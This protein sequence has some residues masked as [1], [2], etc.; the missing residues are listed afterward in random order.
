M[1]AGLSQ[2]QT[3]PIA[4]LEVIDDVRDFAE[5]CGRELIRILGVIGGEAEASQLRVLTDGTRTGDIQVASIRTTVVALRN[6][7]AS[8]P[9]D[10]G[11]ADACCGPDFD[12]ALRWHGARLDE[13]LARLSQ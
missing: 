4:H 10:V 12:A 11:L 2:S 3:S 7:L 13:L 8:A 5:I 6:R 9:S 1:N